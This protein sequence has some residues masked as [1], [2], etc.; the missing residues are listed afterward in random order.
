MMIINLL[1]HSKSV[2]FHTFSKSSSCITFTNLFALDYCSYFA[3]PL[4]GLFRFVLVGK[5]IFT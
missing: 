3:S 2:V 5:G 4:L 1:P